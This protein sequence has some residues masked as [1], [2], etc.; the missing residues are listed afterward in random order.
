MLRYNAT[1]A[2]I[3]R[4]PKAMFRVCSRAGYKPAQCV[5]LTIFSKEIPRS[6]DIW[7]VF[8]NACAGNFRA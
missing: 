2:P 5:Q 3:P 8:S 1:F 6:F 7:G 4:W